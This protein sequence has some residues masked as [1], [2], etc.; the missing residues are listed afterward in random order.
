[1]SSPTRSSSSTTLDKGGHWT[2]E[3]CTAVPG[4]AVPA[5]EVEGGVGVDHGAVGGVLANHLGVAVQQDPHLNSGARFSGF[6][7]Q[8][9]K[10]EYFIVSAHFV[11]FHS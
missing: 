2:R 3:G 5:G 8:M 7:V 11:C 9:V 4:V 6:K 10:P 1:M